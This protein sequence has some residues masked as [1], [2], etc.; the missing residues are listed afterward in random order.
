MRTSKGRT[1]ASELVLLKGGLPS[2]IALKGRRI[3]SKGVYRGV[4]AD[5][6]RPKKLFRLTIN[7]VTLN[8][9]S[10]SRYVL[11]RAELPFPSSCY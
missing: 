6:E 7:R 10:H 4:N 11:L 5:F 3:G 1:P 8:G 9:S 2:D